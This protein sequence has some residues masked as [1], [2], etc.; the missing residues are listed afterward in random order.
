MSFLSQEARGLAPIS[1]T[2]PP[3]PFQRTPA[4]LTVP[5]R[6]DGSRVRVETCLLPA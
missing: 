4:D 6:P 1:Y 5:P 2:L 3:P